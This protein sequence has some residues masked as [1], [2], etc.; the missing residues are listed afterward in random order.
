[1]L[2]GIQNSMLHTV[3][4]MQQV[5]L[6]MLHVAWRKIYGGMLLTL[7]DTKQTFSK[8]SF[9]LANIKVLNLQANWRTGQPNHLPIILS[10]ATVYRDESFGVK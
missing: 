2:N 8:L 10:F 7:I 5:Y 9:K 6:P 1:M 4:C 3:Y